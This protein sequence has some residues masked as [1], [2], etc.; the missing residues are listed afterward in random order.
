MNG[1]IWL[2]IAIAFEASWVIGLRFIEGW[3]RLWPS[4]FVIATYGL[5]LVPLSMAGKSIAPSVLYAVW[6]GGGIISV[7]LADT[8]YFHE[9]VSAPKGICIG[10]IL[11]GA[12]G[13][14][15]LTGGH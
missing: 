3:S 13:L 9:P 6:V 11:A 1:W 4:V 7:F 12:V 15:V 14:K 2:L 10:L 8:F 5:G